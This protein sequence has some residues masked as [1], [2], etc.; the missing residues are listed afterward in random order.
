MN[1]S[2]EQRGGPSADD[3]RALLDF[4]VGHSGLA[5]RLMSDHTDNGDGWCAACAEAFG[6]RAWPCAVYSFA[7]SARAAAR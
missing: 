2:T 4:V 3:Q 5:D 6:Y 7:R 1:H